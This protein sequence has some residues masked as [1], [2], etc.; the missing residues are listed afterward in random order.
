M[1]TTLTFA[2]LI[3]ALGSVLAVAEASQDRSPELMPMIRVQQDRAAYIQLA[4]LH[5]EAPALQYE[6]TRRD[7]EEYEEED[8]QHR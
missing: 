8:D 4:A 1:R 7:R 2:A 6:P 5:A 3:A